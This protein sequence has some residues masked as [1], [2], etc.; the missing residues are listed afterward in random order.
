MHKLLAVLVLIMVTISVT[1]C[2]NTAEGA[3]RDV[4]GMGQ[5]MQDTF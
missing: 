1:G 3:G 4:E 2:T 5:W